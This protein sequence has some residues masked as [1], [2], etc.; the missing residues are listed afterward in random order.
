MN[1][2]I[3]E[4]AEPILTEHTVDKAVEILLNKHEDFSEETIKEV[5]S[6]LVPVAPY[7]FEPYM[8]YSAYVTAVVTCRQAEKIKQT[9]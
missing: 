9:I 2:V 3:F 1:F 5:V 4:N 7:F 8:M 6:L